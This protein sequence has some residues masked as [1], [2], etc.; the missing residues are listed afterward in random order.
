MK[1]CIFTSDLKEALSNVDAIVEAVTS[2]G[3]RP[4]FEQI[5]SIKDVNCPII[6]TSK[7]IEQI[8]A[9]CFLK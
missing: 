3:I 4:V 5:L 8:A 6:L 1:E 2:T 7:G 9:Y